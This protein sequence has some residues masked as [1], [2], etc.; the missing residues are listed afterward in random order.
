MM[1]L[2]DIRSVLRTHRALIV[3]FSGTPRGIGAGQVRSDFPQD[4]LDVMANAGS[5]EVPCSTASPGQS[6]D[7]SHF[8]GEIGLIL[9]CRDG[10][11]L[12]GVCEQDAGSSYDPVA[13]KR[14]I[15]TCKTPTVANCNWSI[16]QRCG[17]NE[18]IVSNYDPVGLFTDRP[19]PHVWDTPTNLQRTML[20]AE[21]AA[22]GGLPLLYFDGT[23]L[24]Q[25]YPE[26]AV[27]NI[28]DFI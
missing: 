12:L 3:H 19:F 8:L 11:S 18:W 26:H 17:H 25:V 7:D 1:L 10:A 21:V 16:E 23:D 2:E 27:R 28:D 14:H 22:F 20:P 4:L 13:G 9:R 6:R 24:V 15:G 5:W